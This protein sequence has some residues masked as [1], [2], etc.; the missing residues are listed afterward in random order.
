MQHAGTAYGSQER[1]LS[2]PV[3]GR[4]IKGVVAFADHAHTD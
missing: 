3:D 4:S 1:N 2:P